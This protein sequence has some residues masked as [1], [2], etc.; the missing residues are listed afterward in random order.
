MR[1]PYRLPPGIRKRLQIGG[2]PIGH[3]DVAIA[4]E[5]KL[6]SIVMAKKRDQ[7]TPNRMAPK[8]GGDKPNAN[9]PAWRAIVGVGLLLFCQ[10]NRL[11]CIPAPRVLENRLRAVGRMK[12]HHVNPIAMDPGIGR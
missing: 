7:R 1:K 10:R 2:Y 4:E 5:F 8:I 12:M 6:L 3:P 11:P 9:A